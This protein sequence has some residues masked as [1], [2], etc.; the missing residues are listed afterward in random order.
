MKGPEIQA[1]LDQK[2][3]RIAAAAEQ[4]SDGGE[5]EVETKPIN[6][7]AVTTV[8]TKDHKALKAVYDNNVLE[9]AKNAGRD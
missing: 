8:R 2:G 3:Q 7:I 9:K 6:W 1:V 4:M 5:F